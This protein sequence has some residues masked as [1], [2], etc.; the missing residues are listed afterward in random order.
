MGKGDTTGVK[1]EGN[2]LVEDPCPGQEL[3][4]KHQNK[5]ISALIL[6]MSPACYENLNKIYNL[7]QILHLYKERV[8]L[9]D[10]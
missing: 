2:V 3:Q 6:V 1:P 5:K 7:P 10:L 9:K 8:G 4:L